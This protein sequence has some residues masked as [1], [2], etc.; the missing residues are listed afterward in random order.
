MTK[1]DLRY[2]KDHEWACVESDGIARIG[3]SNYAQ[4]QLGDVVFIELPAVGAK[5]QQSQ[6][7]GEIESVKAVSDLFMPIA[8]EIVEVNKA[9]IDAPEAVNDDPHGVGWMV[10]IKLDDP[11][12][13]DSLMTSADYQQHIEA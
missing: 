9:L 11:S 3:I 1:S 4:E 12:S 8:G 6:K 10:R 5:I 13:A 2:T 7:L